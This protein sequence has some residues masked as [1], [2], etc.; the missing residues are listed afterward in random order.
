MAGLTKI[1]LFGEFDI[2]G[3]FNDLAPF[4]HL[5]SKV[6]LIEVLPNE[7]TESSE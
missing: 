5:G 7:W 4:C 2:L 1:D 3:L 6:L